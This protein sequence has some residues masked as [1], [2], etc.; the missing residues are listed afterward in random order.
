MRRSIGVGAEVVGVVGVITDRFGAIGERFRPA[1][2]WNLVVEVG[3]R[4]A[5]VLEVRFCAN[6]F[7]SKS[8]A[9]L[10]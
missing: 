9:R 6:S 8:I 2:D 4:A 7:W 1:E 10:E 5:V 3:V